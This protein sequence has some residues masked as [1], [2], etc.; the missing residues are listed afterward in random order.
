MSCATC[1]LSKDRLQGLEFLPVTLSGFNCTPAD[2]MSSPGPA[3][4][5][6]PLLGQLRQL[7]FEL[8]NLAGR[9]WHIEG[10]AN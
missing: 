1:K 5:R 9:A 7:V 2:A 3:A 6:I 8:A 4:S 10:F